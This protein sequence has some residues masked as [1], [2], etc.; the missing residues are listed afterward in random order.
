MDIVGAT[1][2][3]YVPSADDVDAVITVEVVASNDD[4][5]TTA[6]TAATPAVIAA[7]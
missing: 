1:G 6:T 7:A 4:F 2:S 3:S 5:D